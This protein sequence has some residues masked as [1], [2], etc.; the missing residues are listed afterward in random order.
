MFNKNNK[1]AP[2]QPDKAAELLAKKEENT[3]LYE[4]LTNKNREYMVKLNRSLDDRGVPEERKTIIYN[5]MLKN[6]IK[7]QSQHLTARRIYGTVT[8]QANY[9][10][11]NQTAGEQGETVR[12]E[13][14][15][16]YLDGALTAGG[17]YTGITGLISLFTDQ[18]ATM[19]LF[20]AFL[21]FAIG[22]L[23][24]MVIAK[25]APVPG[26]KGGFLKYI[27]ATSGVMIGFVLLM[28]LGAFPSSIN[29][30]LS[31]TISV[32]IGVVAIGAKIYLKRRLSIQ[33]TL[34]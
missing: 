32:I 22:G 7:Q 16:I 12:S 14:W 25:Y 4:Q 19:R 17:A 3:K 9:L 10:T 21:A 23:A 2:E 33:G 24:L 34:F 5:D 8:D 28:T 29:P 13:T 30:M 18:A 20:M 11:E 1:E 26:Q 15:K 27:L 31:P 6:I